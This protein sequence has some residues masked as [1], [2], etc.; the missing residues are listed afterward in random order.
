MMET[1]VDPRRLV[2]QARAEGITRFSVGMILHRAE[3]REFLLL[4]RRPDDTSFPGGEDLPSGGVEP[5]EGLFEGLARELH[6]E[7]GRQADA[8]VRPDPFV[9]WFDYVSRSGNR[10]R[11]FAFSAPYDGAPIRLSE[12]HTGFRWAP[13]REYDRSDL[14][15]QVAGAVRDR[16]GTF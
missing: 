13:M 16:L 1:T 11:W 5:G 15:P 9:S 10:K 4:R 8:P 6:E 12:E 14:S 2:E 7:I 3:G